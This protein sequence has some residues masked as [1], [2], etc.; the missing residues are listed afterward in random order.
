MF[1]F[2]GRKSFRKGIGYHFIGRAVNE[3]KGTTFDNPAYEMEA[4][5]DVFSAGMELVI[6]GKGNGRLIVRK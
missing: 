3:A 6:S 1:D 4:N 5:V 2:G